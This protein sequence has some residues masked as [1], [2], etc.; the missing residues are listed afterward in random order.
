MLATRRV[1]KLSRRTLMFLKST[2][3]LSLPMLPS[4]PT[5]MNTN[6]NHRSFIRFESISLKDAAQPQFPA[7]A[8][9]HKFSL[10]GMT[11]TFSDEVKA[12]IADKSAAAP[13]TSSASSKASSTAAS[14]TSSNKPTGSQS[15][16]AANKTE[17][18]S[19]VSVRAGWAG[20][21][22]AAVVGA[23]LF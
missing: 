11:G 20:A 16:A 2:L 5:A 15:S 17:E 19:G 23:S 18:S 3:L 1:S 22:L 4:A 8:F 6:Q 9:S 10:S 7:L 14:S 21:V 12:Q 13:L